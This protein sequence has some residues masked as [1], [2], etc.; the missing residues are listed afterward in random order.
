[1]LVWWSKYMKHDRFLFS[2]VT[3]VNDVSVFLYW[4]HGWYGISFFFFYLENFFI[5]RS[6][7]WGVNWKHDEMSHSSLLLQFC[8][9]HV[10]HCWYRPLLCSIDWRFCVSFG[11]PG[12]MDMP[13]HMRW[14]CWTFFWSDM[15][16]RG[17][18]GFLLPERKKIC[19]P[20]EIAWKKLT[21]AYYLWVT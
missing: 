20:D 10:Q 9:M 21:M 2:L 16:Y 5:S 19:L 8:L 13:P 18:C 12:T 17:Y 11:R 15:I 14:K 1:M 6:K 3:H 4:E 7:I